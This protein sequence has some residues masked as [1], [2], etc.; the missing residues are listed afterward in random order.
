M[1]NWFHLCVR[2]RHI[3]G[4]YK[5]WKKRF[6]SKLHVYFYPSRGWSMQLIDSGLAVTKD[7]ACLLFWPSSTWSKTV[8]QTTAIKLTAGLQ[9]ERKMRKCCLY[10]DISWN[11]NMTFLS[12]VISHKDRAWCQIDWKIECLSDAHVHEWRSEGSL[13]KEEAI[14]NTVNSGILRI[15]YLYFTE[16]L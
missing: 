11:L 3:S 14:E 8:T 13:A 4:F 12:P 9:K 16:Q 1:E 2:I 5:A 10:K 7:L 6:C 15:L